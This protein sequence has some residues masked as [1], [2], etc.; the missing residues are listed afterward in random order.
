MPLSLLTP[1]VCVCVC[2]C[3]RA[4]VCVYVCVCVCVC[5]SQSQ[6]VQTTFVHVQLSPVTTSTTNLH[7]QN[8]LS[9][10]SHVI[11]SHTNILKGHGYITKTPWLNHSLSY[12]CKSIIN[13][14]DKTLQHTHRS[15]KMSCHTQ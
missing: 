4:F 10:A 9:I 15:R 3:V 6:K 5:V 1:H 13:N 14:P 7:V 8:I 11:S 12:P 2:V